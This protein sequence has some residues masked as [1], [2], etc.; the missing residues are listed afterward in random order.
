MLRTHDVF[1]FS[2]HR[3]RL[4]GK[5][6]RRI[7]SK[8]AGVDVGGGKPETVAYVCECKQ[9]QYKIIRMGAWRG[10][11]TRGQV[12]ILEH[13]LGAAR[14]L[15]KRGPPQSSFNIESKPSRKSARDTALGEELF[16]ATGAGHEGSIAGPDSP[17]RFI[18]SLL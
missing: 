14:L 18:S 15:R 9:G 8:T 10:E 12:V 13:R 17:L 7:H 5:R 16:L 2:D 6:R 1:G 11:D 4:S 3:W